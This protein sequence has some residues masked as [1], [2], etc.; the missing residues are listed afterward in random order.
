M[1]VKK[2]KA[3]KSNEKLDASKFEMYFDFMSPIMFVKPHQV[4]AINRGESLKLLS[5]KIIVPDS[6]KFSLKKFI[7]SQY[8]TKGI[9]YKVRS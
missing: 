9:R 2:S 6:L 8:M 5:V 1:Q 3:T 7:E 4:L